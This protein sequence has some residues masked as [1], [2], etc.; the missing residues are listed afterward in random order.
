MVLKCKV[1]NRDTF[2]YPRDLI[3]S[4]AFFLPRGT[5]KRCFA[6]LQKIIN[7]LNYW[8]LSKNIFFGVV[9]MS[10]DS[11]FNKISREPNES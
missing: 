7:Q 9:L 11:A 6:F 2:L 10:C 3:V 5:L 4:A 8:K 1:V